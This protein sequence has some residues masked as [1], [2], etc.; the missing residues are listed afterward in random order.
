MLA[1]EKLHNIRDLGG[2]AGLGGRRIREGKLI[3]SGHLYE[4]SD[5]DKEALSRLV[6]T[7]VD[8][9]T[10]GERREKPDIELPGV[11]NHHIKVIKSLTEGITREAAAD[12]SVFA[13]LGTDSGKAKKY[14]CGLYR[15]FGESDFSAAQYA[16]FVRI[17]MEP[18]EK[19]VLWHCTAG[20]D[21]AGVGALIVEEILGVGRDDIIDDYLATNE[22]LRGDIEFMI[23]FIKEQAG[24]SASLSDRALGYLLSAD[25]DYIE[26]YYRTINE[27]YGSF[28]GFVR[29]GL[30]LT[31][32]DIQK[33]QSMYLFEAA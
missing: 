3:R 26:E 2:M 10:D 17:L 15:A 16:L 12:K 20:K 18:G 14:M 9:R 25:R 27:K 4:V 11:R 31:S 7:V 28:D 30:K 5:S 33:L 32:E 21:R 23:E 8:F 24:R 13:R 22:Y 19:A 1:F 6:S 29:D